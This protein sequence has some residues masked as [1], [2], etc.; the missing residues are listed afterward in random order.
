MAFNV[1]YIYEILDRYSAPLRKIVDHVKKFQRNTDIAK[2]R[3]DHL[4]KSLAVMSGGL[5]ATGH[6]ASIGALP[7]V[8]KLGSR[9]SWLGMMVTRKAIPPFHNFKRILRRFITTARAAQKGA[10]SLGKKLRKIGDG[11]SSLGQTMATRITAMGVIIAGFALKASADMEQLQVAFG[12]MLGSMD[13]GKK[14]I[15]DLANFAARTPFQLT[16]IGNATRRLLAFGFEGK[17]IMPT[18]N[19]LGDISAGTGKDLSELSVIFGQ[20]KMAGRLMGQDFLQFVNAGVPVATELAKILAKK[21]GGSIEQNKRRLKDFMSKGLISFG[22]VKKAMQNMVA[23][24]GRFNGMMDKQ[25]KT[26]GGLWST[27]KDN[28]HLALVALGDTLVKVFNLKGLLARV[29]E[30][31]KNLREKFKIWADTNPELAKLV[32]TFAGLL[33][34]IGPLL[35]VLGPLV[36]LFG[37]L[38]AGAGAVSLVIVAVVAGVALLVAMFTRWNNINHPVI[39][40]LK[41]LWDALGPI[42]SVFGFLIDRL[43]ALVSWFV[44]TNTEAG[45]LAHT[46]DVIGLALIPVIAAITGLLNLLFGE[47]EGNVFE[48][49]M[50]DLNEFRKGTSMVAQVYDNMV[51]MVANWITAIADFFKM[52]KDEI[53]GFIDKASTFTSIMAKTGMFGGLVQGIANR[54]GEKSADAKAQNASNQGVDI[55]GSIAVQGK[56]GTTI[57]KAAINLNQGDN[58]AT[59]MP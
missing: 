18:L 38:F 50:A 22:M 52:L 8:I 43:S 40:S 13:K 6:A 19:M 41:R 49:M 9:F 34:T 7:Q 29:I 44:G 47:T 23:E 54:P 51:T 42:W 48:G 1:S 33:M 17:Q 58:L 55:S 10:T 2:K 14:M 4:S 45:V 30:V 16:G 26:L 20:V 28:V 37:W 56:D 11:M 32:L 5:V 57:E 24:G 59:V 53:T 21:F 25:S 27:L 3:T 35:L 46:F 39:K 36:K 12:V 31:V 15:A